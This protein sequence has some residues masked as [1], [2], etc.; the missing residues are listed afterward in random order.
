MCK[1]ACKYFEKSNRI[2]SRKS[3]AAL[4]DIKAERFGNENISD[5]IILSVQQIHWQALTRAFY[6]RK[7]KKQFEKAIQNCFFGQ[8]GDLSRIKNGKKFILLFWKKDLNI[9]HV[10]KQ[11]KNG[12]RIKKEIAV[13]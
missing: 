8:W 10:S 11:N 5:Q 1:G 9:L 4:T 12:A 6:G 7:P 3:R 2:L 13:T